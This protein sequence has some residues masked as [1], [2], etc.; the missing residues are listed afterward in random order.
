MENYGKETKKNQKKEQAENLQEKND[1]Q[2]CSRQGPIRLQ[3]QGRLAYQQTQA[4]TSPCRK[5]VTSF[6][7]MVRKKRGPVV[8]A[9]SRSSSLGG[10]GETNFGKKAQKEE[11]ARNQYSRLHKIGSRKKTNLLQRMSFCES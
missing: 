1:G 6:C 4:V 8:S 11:I 2:T 9:G 10:P 3:S 5:D 7:R